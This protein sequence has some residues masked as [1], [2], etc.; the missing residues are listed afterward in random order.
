MVEKQE[1]LKLV[2]LGDRVKGEIVMPKLDLN[3]FIGKK[4]KIE[5]IQEGEGQF[6]FFV[7]LITEPVGTL[8]AIDKTTG[9]KIQLRGS[10]RFGLL[11]NDKEEI[12][13]TSNSKLGV[14]LNKHNKKHY[15]DCTGMTVIIQLHTSTKDNKDYLTFN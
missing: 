8:N 7:D 2:N 14:F 5:K 3:E 13:W 6:G 10:A 12:G 11:T 15:R 4:V 9:E 1:S